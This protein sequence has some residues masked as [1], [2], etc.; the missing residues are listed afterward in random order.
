MTSKCALPATVDL[1]PLKLALPDQCSRDMQPSRNRA[2][3][4]C[5][6]ES[7]LSATAAAKN[8]GAPLADSESADFPALMLKLQQSGLRALVQKQVDLGLQELALHAS[9]TPACTPQK[10]DKKHVLGN[11]ELQKTWQE[12]AARKQINEQ[13]AAAQTRD[14]ALSRELRITCAGEEWMLDRGWDA[15]DLTKRRKYL[16][17]QLGGSDANGT[18]VALYERVSHH[19][20]VLGVLRDAQIPAYRPHTRVQPLGCARIRRVQG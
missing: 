15:P 13:P 3:A 8:I 9:C 11:A 20:V 16:Q 4:V 12:H 6:G 10:T 18:R 14:T 2:T 7:P 17:M 1:D 19:R 5:S